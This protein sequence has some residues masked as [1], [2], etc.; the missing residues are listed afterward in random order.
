[1]KRERCA[2]SAAAECAIDGA[3]ANAPI[4]SR[5]AVR[6]NIGR[7]PGCRNATKSISPVKRSGRPISGRLVTR[8]GGTEPRV[9]SPCRPCLAATAQLWRESRCQPQLIELSAVKLTVDM[10]DCTGPHRWIV[11][12]RALDVRER[13]VCEIRARSSGIVGDRELFRLRDGNCRDVFQWSSGS[14]PA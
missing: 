14:V 3:P 12:D 1:M 2:L 10:Y 9:S 8:S 4:C 13:D 5:S 7:I 6:P 11:P